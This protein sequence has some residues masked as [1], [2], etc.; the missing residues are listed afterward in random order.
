MRIEKLVWNYTILV[1]L[2]FPDIF[3][4]FCFSILHIPLKAVT[5]NVWHLGSNPTESGKKGFE[6]RF[7]YPRIMCTC[8][9]V[10]LLP[11]P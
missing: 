6:L 11:L 10:T 1:E 5:N 7:P 2:P 9:A 4:K 3:R 8:Y